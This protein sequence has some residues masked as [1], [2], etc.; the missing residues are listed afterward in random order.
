MRLR[1]GLLLALLLGGCFHLSADVLY[2]VTDLVPTYDI[3]V[4]AINN[5]GQVTGAFLTSGAYHAFLYSN[6]QM[7]NLN[8]L[9][10]PTLGITLTDARAINDKGQIVA[11]SG[12][13]SGVYLLTPT[14][15]VP[16]PS[17][18]ALFGA[19]LVGLGV[20][21]WMRKSYCL[22]RL[23]SSVILDSCEPKSE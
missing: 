17:T 7:R 23:T 8:D 16:E 15:T 9:I 13:S 11:N 21:R 10:D 2:S 3:P 19:A 5:A 4:S 1:S 22:I 14:S 20:G 6:G 18:W 12:A